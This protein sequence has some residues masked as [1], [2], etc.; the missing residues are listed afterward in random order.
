MEKK[1]DMDIKSIH[2]KLEDYYKQ[3]KSNLN[4]IEK[5]LKDTKIPTIKD[6]LEDLS[7]TISNEKKFIESFEA[8]RQYFIQFIGPDKKP[9]SSK[10][11]NLVRFGQY[12]NNIGIEAGIVPDSKSNPKVI[13]T[14]QCIEKL[15]TSTEGFDA[16]AGMNTEKQLMNAYYIYPFEY[17]ALFKKK[18]KG[19]LLY[20]VP[21]TGKTQLV[22][23]ATAELKNAI[24][25]A[26]K[27]GE[28][29]GKHE[30][31]TEKAI[32]LVFKCASARLDED[33]TKKQAILFFDEFDAIAAKSDSPL[34]ARARGALLQSID[35]VSSD[36]RVS[37]IAATNFPERIDD[38]IN[39]RFNKKIFVDLPDREARKFIIEK[40]IIEN[41][42]SPKGILLYKEEY[43]KETD[44]VKQK[45][46]RNKALD[47]ALLNIKEYG[48]KDIKNVINKMPIIDEKFIDYLSIY[49]G[50]KYKY[51]E[52][53]KKTGRIDWK[54]ECP[55]DNTETEYGYS[56][57]DIDKIMS[58]AITTTAQ[59]AISFQENIFLELTNN[60]KTVRNYIY[61]NDKDT[62][63]KSNLVETP[64][65]KYI[66]LS[67]IK[68]KEDIITY[69]ISP[70]I[71]ID[72][73]KDYKV[74]YDPKVYVE[75]V[76]K[77][78]K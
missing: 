46:I 24:I 39:R 58:I 12:V 73:I 48:I 52:L 59:N 67:E 77:L 25:L 74:T 71:I 40:H 6:G 45:V 47:G 2:R 34:D 15:S 17:P 4:L 49:T 51:R 60:D 69:A 13:D 54:V 23:A 30:G 65:M 3:N 78:Q 28:L 76:N 11:N 18:T 21:G 22:L 14:S 41:Y 31:D 66:E 42:I 61:I 29:R 5:E 27:P 43:K 37:I 62:E 70:S 1:S 50:P 53:I 20:G 72:A 26:P 32:E 7:K 33:K 35:G 19:I 68:N 56:A 9:K 75:M 55:D 64:N 63:Y 38:A 8:F 16:L 36:P 44:P 57:S 10:Y